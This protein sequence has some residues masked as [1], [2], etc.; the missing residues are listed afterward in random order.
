MK[1]WQI[2]A[3]ALVILLVT[4]ACGGVATPRVLNLYPSPTVL[5]TQTPVYIE[6]EVQVTTVVERT[7][8]V[9]VTNTP[10]S[11]GKFCVSAP[12]AVHLR[13]SPNDQNYPIMALPNGA[14]LTDLGGR[15]ENWLFVQ[16][17]DQEGQVK[18]GWVNGA[19]VADCE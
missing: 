11:V 7:T 19:Y 17:V 2:I 12:V 5:A 4:L 18:Q 8:I 14:E 1:R 16:Y 3:G 10:Q 13:P 15:D 6:K 9:E